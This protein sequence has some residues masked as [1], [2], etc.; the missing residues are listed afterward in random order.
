MAANTGNVLNNRKEKVETH[1]AIMATPMKIIPTP[2]PASIHLPHRRVALSR[3]SSAF[4]NRAAASNGTFSPSSVTPLE[5][6]AVAA[7]EGQEL[8]FWNQPLFSE[9]ENQR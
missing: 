6:V 5:T 3:L 1:P 2:P 8:V 4:A 7:R 9:A